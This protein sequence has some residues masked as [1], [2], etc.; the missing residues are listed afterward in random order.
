VV[1]IIVIAAVAGGS[2][3]KHTASTTATTDAT[4]LVT[5]TTIP[6]TTI[7]TTTE[8]P[9]TT[10]P[11]AV[12][13]AIRSAQQ[14]LDLGSGFSRLGLIAQLSSSAVGFPQDVATQAVD[15]LNEDWNAQAVLA[16]KDYMNL[17]AFSCSGLVGQLSSS[18]VQ[19]TLTEAQYG[20]KQV[21]IC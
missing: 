13:N 3:K 4:Q 9:T 1:V 17:E 8:A 10:L 11:L 12:R 18:A 15:S 6:T 2:K 20:A 7:P 5:T 19:F 14:Y 16:A 21:G